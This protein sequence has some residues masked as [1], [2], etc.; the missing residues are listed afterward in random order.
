[1]DAWLK[2]FWVKLNTSAADLWKNDKLFL[3]LFGV[4]ILVFKFRSLLVDLIVSDSEAVFKKAQQTSDE[5]T[6][7]ET[8]NNQAADEL[9]A[10]AEKLNSSQGNVTDDW[11]QK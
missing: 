5:L 6:K 9:I 3:I 4:I 10:H 1:M 7:N 11:N 2:A 8:K